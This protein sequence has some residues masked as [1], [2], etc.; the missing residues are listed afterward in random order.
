MA[1][2]ALVSLVACNP[3]DAVNPSISASIT[4]TAPTVP[5]TTVPATTAAPTT[6]PPTT[7]TAPPPTACQALLALLDR[8]ER[9]TGIRTRQLARTPEGVVA[10][11]TPEARLLNRLV[12]AYRTLGESTAGPT[13]RTIRFARVDPLERSV[14]WLVTTDGRLDPEASDSDRYLRA[15][16]PAVK[17]AT[18]P[19]LP[20]RA[21]PL[22]RACRRV[23][24]DPAATVLSAGTEF[25]GQSPIP[26]T[27]VL[28]EIGEALDGFVDPSVLDALPR[29]CRDLAPDL[30]D[31]YASAI[32]PPR[33]YAEVSGEV[34]AWAGFLCEFGPPADNES[35]TVAHVRL[36]S[37]PNWFARN[38]SGSERSDSLPGA[39]IRTTGSPIWRDR[40]T[41][42]ETWLAAAARDPVT[43]AVVAVAV[44]RRLGGQARDA[45]LAEVIEDLSS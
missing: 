10:P 38:F 26:G 8:A 13:A 16:L 32:G 43:G 39:L 24:A 17:L 12:S 1:L 9:M 22:L 34:L 2:I 15:T 4:T 3:G 31:A 27:A 28:R 19:V 7:T 11:L 41:S 36:L 18:V 45:A 44:P 20:P 6:V 33:V 29:R 21:Q 30:E 42:G 35:A 5:S 40:L 37:A 23:E 14:R 25:G